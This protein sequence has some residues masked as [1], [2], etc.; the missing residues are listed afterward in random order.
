MQRNE[1]RCDG[2]ARGANQRKSAAI[3]HLS[4]GLQVEPAPE[5]SGNCDRAEYDT[6]AGCVSPGTGEEAPAVAEERTMTACRFG[7]RARIVP[8]T[9]TAPPSQIHFTSGFRY[10]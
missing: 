8:S 6:R 7:R 3:S 4:R 9:T 1:G 5:R 10:A 2:H